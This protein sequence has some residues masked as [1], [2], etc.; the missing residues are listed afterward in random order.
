[1]TPD[2]IR[3]F[4]RAAAGVTLDEL[5]DAIAAA[6]LPAPPAVAQVGASWSTAAHIAAVQA[7]EGL[8]EEE[9]RKVMAVLEM[10]MINTITQ[11]NCLDVMRA[12]P[13]SSVDLICSDPP[14]FRVKS[15][16]D[17]AFNWW[18]SQWDKPA[19]FLRWLDSIAAEW[20]RILKPNGSLYCF[21]SPRMA[22]RVEVMLGER[23]N[24]LNRITWQKPSFATK[25]EMTKKEDLRSFFPASEAIIFCEHY[26]ADNAAKGEAGYGAKCDE[27]RGFVFE[28]LRA[29]LDGERERAGFSIHGVAEAFQRKTGSRT[30][31][32][33]ARHWF[34]SVQWALPTAENY[35]WLR[36]LFNPNGDEYLRREY[37]ELR[38]E[39]E[40]L[41]RPFTVSAEVPYTDVWTF[42]TV[43]AYK[44]KHPCEKPLALLENVVL[45]SSRPGAIVLDCFCGSGN[46]LLAAKKHGR[47]FIG[48]D[49]D[50]HWVDVARGRVGQTQEFVSHE[51]RLEWLHQHAQIDDDQRYK[52]TSLLDLVG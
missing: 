19:E 17:N 26:G 43:Q 3:Q 6:G 14:Y 34:T 35:L 29:Y 33:M 7:V 21:A 27:L 2:H 39:Y 31:T 25:A 11:G 15:S 23:F 9:V 41:R 18:D 22:A 10:P 51:R 42:P 49:I 5:T 37:E 8:P 46:T 4:R 45:A 52:Q 38:Q 40:E 32:G 50:P 28:P 24:V 1:M 44:G 48:I 16:V 47:N 13:D 20:Q 30:V 12:L 36:Q